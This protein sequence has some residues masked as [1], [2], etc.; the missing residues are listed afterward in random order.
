MTESEQLQSSNR[1]RTTFYSYFRIFLITF[2]WILIVGMLCGLLIG[3]AVFGYV[4][5]TVKNDPIRSK[6]LILQKMKE[7]DI[8]GF[9]YFG[10]DSVIGQ[11]RTEEDRRIVEYKDLPEHLINAVTSIED[12][13]FFTHP[14]I[15]V[16]GLVRAVKQKVLKEDIQTGGST[17]TQQL[18]RRV[19]LSLDK[20]NSRK[21]KEIFL[22]LRLERYMSKDEILVAYLNKVPFGNGASGYNL[23]GIK[24]AAKGIFNVDDLNQL[25]IAQSA[26]LAGLPQSP[27]TYSLFS[28]KGEFDQEGFDKATKRMELVLS[29]MHEINKISE[30]EYRSALAFDLKSSIAESTKKAYTTY[31][32]LMLES[33]KQAAELLLLQQDPKLTLQQI[34][35]KEY[36]EAVKDARDHLLRGGYKIYT[37]IDKTLYDAMH[38]ISNNAENFTPDSKTKGVEQI[39]AIMLNNKDGSILGMIEGRD[40]YLEQ[41]NYATQMLRQPGSTMKPIAAYLPAIEKGSI[42]PASVIDDAPIILKDYQKGFHIPVNWN[43][44]YQGLVTAREALNK[45][46]NLPALKIFLNDVGIENAW[47]FSRR[48]GITSLSETDNNAQTGVIGGLSDGVSVEELTNAYSAIANQGEFNDAFMIRKIEDSEGKIIYEH[49]IK[50]ERVVSEQSA[51]LMTDMLRTVITDKQGTGASMK[52]D[53]KHYGKT[54]IVGK[55]G[56]TQNYGD[57][58]FMGYSPDITLGV[59]AGYEK[60]IHSLSKNGKNRAKK[61]WAKVMDVAME[62]NPELF[63]TTKFTKPN[64]IIS[65]TV[66]NVSGMLP[67]ELIKKTNHLVTDIFN[68]KDIPTSEDNMMINEKFIS[69]NGINY[70]ANPSTPEDFLV[71]KM[72]I[73]REKPIAEIIA[74]ITKAQEKIPADNRRPLTYYVPLDASN[75]APTAQDPRVDDGKAPVAARMVTL[76]TPNNAVKISFHTS[77]STD[78]I[79]YR[80]YRSFNGG[81]YQKING[82]V[83]FTG[84]E[85]KFLDYIMKTNNYSYYIAAVDIAGNESA[86]SNIV[87][88]G[89]TTN[90][91]NGSGDITNPI[92]IPQKPKEETPIQEQPDE[93]TPDVQQEV[94]TLSNAPVGVEIS[95]DVGITIRW[96]SNAAA[97]RVN[98]YNVYYSDKKNGNYKFIGSTE[99]N[100]FEYVSFP[101][102]GW[103]H[104][105]AVNSIGE[106]IPSSN[107]QYK[108]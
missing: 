97:E 4:S 94:T 36:A 51:Y 49:E 105:T 17:L 47:N 37:T 66:S 81:E 104:V 103:Y 78:V 72:V 56:S 99:S 83:V 67:S 107:V 54:E 57:V 48:L 92:L 21:I 5:A 9:V 13:N 89:T 20:T 29:E 77:P 93:I 53:F 50:P 96:I 84:Q 64:Q 19:F 63:P 23:Y 41:M 82:K 44:K 40:F 62:D 30:D 102:S 101:L 12:K 43:H 80:L 3:G 85:L 108:E 52:N 61:I 65:M 7:D 69:Y 76:T 2:K 22:S 18:A 98:T 87:S 34:R 71:K 27:S 74:E 38:I 10:D 11:L 14:G 26:Y 79:G 91:S 88:I 55:T 33:E 75:D 90:I 35:K 24:A 25:N 42:Q 70:V 95:G 15:S 86:R 60:Q 6:A 46:L 100:E 31:P 73:K 32:Y 1:K 59:W 8:T 39:A 106:S 16:N 28:G 68:K 58:W 45:S